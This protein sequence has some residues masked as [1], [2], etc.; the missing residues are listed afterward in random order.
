MENC[1]KCGKPLSPDWIL[2]PYCGARPAAKRSPS[3]RRRP[4]GSGTAFRR[5]STWYAQICL[6]SAI[7]ASGKPRRKLKTKGGFKTKTEALAYCEILRNGAPV[8]SHETLYSLFQ[9]WAPTHEGRVGPSTMAGYRAAFQHFSSIHGMSVPLIRPSDWQACIDACPRGKRTK[10]DMRTVAGLLNK[11]AMDQD[12]I[13]RNYAANLYTGRDRKGTRPAFTWDEVDAIRQAVGALPYADYVYTLIYTGFRPSELFALTK[14]SYNAQDNTLTGGAK[15]EAG[16]DRVVPVYSGLL[17]ILQR[18]LE[19]P[20]RWLFPRAD[21]TQ[22]NERYFRSACFNPLMDQLGITDR[23]PYS[24][25]HTFANLLKQVRGSDTDKAAIIGHA[26]ASM[27]KYY[28]SADLASLRSII[29]QFPLP[30][31]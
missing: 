15:T 12:I 8:N 7:D 6:G 30:Q 31:K 17:P 3:P 21:G 2:C 24:C 16:R 18:R 23:L 26:D 13:P 11:F 5:G 22:M 1:K 27:T 14:D 10:E 28:Q 4:N 9:R 20:S 25:R 19:S 29:D